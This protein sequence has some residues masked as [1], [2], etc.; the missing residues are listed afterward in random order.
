MTSKTRSAI[1]SALVFAGASLMSS[2]PAFAAAPVTP[3]AV[4]GL[5]DFADL[6]D[7]VGPAVVNIRTTE[8]VRLDQ[9]G[10]PDEE[11]QE[12]LRRFFGGLPPRLPPPP[13]PRPGSR[14][15]RRS[16]EE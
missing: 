11:M 2:S 15:A 13:P 16:E 5:P 4:A 3:T 12:F 1:L 8:R 10:G 14:S 9:G 7:K 6:V